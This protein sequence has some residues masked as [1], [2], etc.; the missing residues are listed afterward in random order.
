GM[1]ITEG[2]CHLMDEGL[3]SGPIVAQERVEVPDG[4]CYAQLEA[5]CAEAGGILLARSVWELYQGTAVPRPQDKSQSSYLPL[6][7]S[8][9]FVV[10]VAQWEARHVY[11]FIRGVAS[12]GEPVQLLI[13]GQNVLVT[14]AN[15]YSHE[16]T[17]NDP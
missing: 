5:Q 9:D 17:D 14:D 1:L 11:N 2:T 3:D 6:P 4:I 7:S 13:D 16:N 15:S 12:R 10:P 8:E